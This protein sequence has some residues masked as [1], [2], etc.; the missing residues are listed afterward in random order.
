[1]VRDENREGDYS[2]DAR[3]VRRPYRLRVCTIMGEFITGPIEKLSR[4]AVATR[5]QELCEH[6][7]SRSLVFTDKDGHKWVLKPWAVTWF[8][9]EHAP[10]P[11]PQRP[12]WAWWRQ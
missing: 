12:W 1:M 4:V 9:L 6:L 7:E 2:E 10:P 11:E 5:L 3:A 8:K